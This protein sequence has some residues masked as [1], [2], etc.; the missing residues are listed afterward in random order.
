VTYVKVGREHG[1]DI[2]I[3]YRDHGA[4]RPIVLVHG[5]PLDEVNAALLDF[6]GGT[7]AATNGHGAVAAGRE[8]AS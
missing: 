4:A 6:L 5:Y 3:H 8:R 1:T 2:A 7:G